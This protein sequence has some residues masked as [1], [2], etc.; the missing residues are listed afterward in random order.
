LQSGK[1]RNIPGALA[2]HGRELHLDVGAGA[3]HQQHDDEEGV[4]VEQ[5]RLR[6]RQET[7][8]S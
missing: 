4:E 7:T 6:S 3:D 1:R 5:R 8:V 2:E